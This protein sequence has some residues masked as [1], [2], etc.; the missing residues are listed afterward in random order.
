MDSVYS[1]DIS[2]DLETL[3]VL[4]KDSPDKVDKAV[5]RAMKKLSRYA[6]RQL[7]R[8]LS[9]AHPLSQAQLKKLRRLRLKVFTPNNAV[10][11]Y[12]LLINFGTNPVA[13]HY[14]GK[15]QQ[16]PKGVKA[17]KEFWK[18]AFIVPQ[19]SSG[20][21]RVFKRKANWK[22]KY[23]RSRRSGRMM[24]M[25]LPMALQRKDIHEDAVTVMNALQPQL[26]ERFSALVSQELN[27]AFN[28]E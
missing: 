20:E 3:L 12:A 23:V 22:H 2:A 1:I 26:A 4:F 24:W 27:Y 6:E 17:G 14:Y 18:G 7:L 10:N 8:A 15:P 19:T 11:D 16:R 13:A 21:L 5:R 28:I 25:G 9:R